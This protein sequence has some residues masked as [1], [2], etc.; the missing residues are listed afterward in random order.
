VIPGA[1]C[2]RFI[3]F[4]CG[5]VPPRVAAGSYP[6]FNPGTI[7]VDPAARTAYV[8]DEAGGISVIPL[9]P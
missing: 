1:F 5:L 6:G 4:G 2:N 7:A 3:S 8:A 9:A